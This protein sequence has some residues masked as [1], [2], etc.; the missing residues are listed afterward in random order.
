MIKKP[1]GKR[2]FW[3]IKKSG[4]QVES[5]T[6][7]L[8]FPE[9]KDEIEK[10]IMSIFCKELD[11]TKLFKILTPPVKISENDI[12]F[13]MN[14]SLGEMGI[15]FVE[16][17][18]LTKEGYRSLKSE[19]SAEERYEH[20]KGLIQSKSKKYENYTKTSLK[21]LI[22]YNTDGKLGLIGSITALVIKYCHTNKMIFNYIFYLNPRPDLT[23]ILDLFYPRQK[24]IVE[25]VL[26]YNEADLRKDGYIKIL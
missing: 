25:Q 24:E 15:E 4:T 1:T 2:T 9:T 23:G 11:Q 6:K 8:Q 7:Y 19:F 14:T 21:S 12:D 3:E 22:I 10:L 17:A 13:H 18:P 26:S 16:D 5:S 20:L